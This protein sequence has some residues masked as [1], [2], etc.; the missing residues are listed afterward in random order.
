MIAV[1][2]LGATREVGRLQGYLGLFLRDE[3]VYDEATKQSTPSM[4]TAWEPT[5]DELA[6]L[7]NGAKVEIM[8][9]GNMPPPMIVKV[10]RVP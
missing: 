4:T 1:R 10:G 7:N 9:L 3:V 5:P 8:I 2:I 6:R